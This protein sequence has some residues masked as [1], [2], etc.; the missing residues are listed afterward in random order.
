MARKGKRRRAVPH[1]FQRRTEPGAP[2]GTLIPDPDAPRCEIHVMAYGAEGYEEKPLTS[3]ADLPKLL[4]KWPVTWVNVDGVGDAALV[5]EL[6]RLFQLHRLALEDVLHVHQRAKA[7]SYGS[8]YFI[9]ARMPVP[10]HP[11]QTE[12]I[13]FF[14]GEKFVL[15]FQERPGG[16]CLDAVRIRIRTGWGRSRAARPDYLVYALLDSIV[17]HFFPLIEECGEQLDDLEGDVSGGPV[18]DIMA[19]IHHIKRHLL[20]VRRIIWPLR[21]AVNTL[22]RDAT[23]L[24]SDDTRLYLRDVHD[25][26]IQILDLVE[27]YRDISSGITEIYL[28]SVSQRTNEIVKVLTII[29]T[30]FIP[31]TFLAGLYGMNFNYQ[32]SPWNM[33]ELHSYWGYPVL[34]AVMIAT[35]G[36]MLLLFRRRGWLGGE[37]PPSPE[38]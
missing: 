18:P 36:A 25:H 4:E 30:I 28:S 27:S 31:L 37:R 23:P 32:A 24:I 2:P 33:P 6:G 11:W 12:Q 7:E 3:L 9:V 38:E 16:D 21:D 15:T 22:L 35:A 14:F 17:D 26:T 20:T 19:R 8:Y 29:S 34:L 1:E 13:S 5:S 10:Q